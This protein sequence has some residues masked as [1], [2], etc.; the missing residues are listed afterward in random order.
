MG[1]RLRHSIK[2]MF[3]SIKNMFFN[4]FWNMFFNMFFILWLRANGL[5]FFRVERKI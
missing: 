3:W 5:L 4:I 2:N 1:T